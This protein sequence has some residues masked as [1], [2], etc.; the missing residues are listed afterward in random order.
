MTHFFIFDDGEALYDWLGRILRLITIFQGAQ[1]GRGKLRGLIAGRNRS[2]GDQR[3]RFMR[4]S[5]PG[6]GKRIRFPISGF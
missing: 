1:E 2:A 5:K 4:Q 6:V 3:G